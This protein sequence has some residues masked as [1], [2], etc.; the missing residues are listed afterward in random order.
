MKLEGLGSMTPQLEKSRSC[1]RFPFGRYVVKP[2]IVIA[3]WVCPMGMDLSGISVGAASQ[4]RV[5][6]Q[7]GGLK[8]P[9][10]IAISKGGEIYVSDPVLGVVAILDGYGRRVGT[11]TGL[12]EPL[13]VAHSQRHRRERRRGW[14]CG[15]R[16]PR[17][18]N[19]AY[20]GDQGDGSVH[21]FA[22]D[23]FVR[24]LGIGAGEFL[25]PNGIAVT[26]KQVVYVADSEANHIKVFHADGTLYTI[27]GTLLDF[28]TDIAINEQAGEVYVSAFNQELIVVFDLQGNFLREITAPS[29]DQGDPAFFRIAGLGINPNGN[30][31]VVD[32]ALSSVTTITPNGAL[33][34]IIG[35][36]AG[37]TYGTGELDVPI[38]AASDGE[39]IFVTSSRDRLVK[40]FAEANP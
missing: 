1:S 38:D 33:V 3:L 22:N 25:K 9:T 17:I 4:S 27:F 39:Y 23:E 2:A 13:G 21:V 29:N 6:D 26:K 28:P 16:P 18:T 7:F 24:T 10:R 30:L 8:R 20:V 32:S 35:Y 5:I 36:E 11:L 12:Q 19:F 37:G 31:H 14:S 15:P 40:V 34:D